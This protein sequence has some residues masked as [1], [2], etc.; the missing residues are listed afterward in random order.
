VDPDY[1]GIDEGPILAMIE[2]YRSDL[3]WRVMRGNRY[4]RQ[5]L[6]GAGFSGGWLEDTHRAVPGLPGSSATAAIIPLCHPACVF[7]SMTGRKRPEGATPSGLGRND[8]SWGGRAG[9]R[10][11][12]TPLRR[13]RQRERPRGHCIRHSLQETT[14]IRFMQRFVPVNLE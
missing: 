6:D 11:W 14:R 13:T 2:N 5:G 10:S 3:I 4:L 1:V 9:D 8:R 12:P 7:Q